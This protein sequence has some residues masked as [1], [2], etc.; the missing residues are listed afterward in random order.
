VVPDAAGT[1]GGTALR[2]AALFA[3]V[4]VT[5]GL[6]R[7]DAGR[8]DLL[9]PSVR[10]PATHHPRRRAEYAAGRLAAYRALRT[11]TGH[12]H[13]LDRADNGSPAWPCGVRG[14]L[15]HSG[16]LAVC[17][18]TTGPA[19]V[20]V[21]IE[22]LASAGHLHRGRHLVGGRGEQRLAALE[23]DP[24]LAVLRLFS[25]KEAAYKAFPVERQPQMTF[26]R[27][28]LDWDPGGSSRTVELRARE[29]WARALRVVS[30]VHAGHLVSAA[31]FPARSGT[32]A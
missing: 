28:T 10:L 9:P 26:R 22:P 16:T 5:V 30:A 27:L 3:P 31:T 18:L 21:D 12:G 24:E 1:G 6:A 17:V 15:T 11:A 14:S 25:A 19:A 13:W 20:G 8:H 7:V 32:T 23:P 2:V 29:A 4:A